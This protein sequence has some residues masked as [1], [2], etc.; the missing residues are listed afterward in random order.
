[1]ELP[2]YQVDA[3]TSRVFGGNPAAVCPLRDWLPAETM[4]AI[5]AENNLA[6]TAFF[7]KQEDGYGLRWF[8]PVVEMPLCGH[9]TLA[10]A[11][12]IFRHLEPEAAV[13][14]F[15]TK[16]G[17]LA[18]E[19]EGERLVLDFPA[20]PAARTQPPP[21]LA[22]GLGAHALEVWKASYY[23]AVFA[24]EDEVRGLQPDMRV[25]CGLDPVI[26]TAPGSEGIDFVSRFFAPSYGIDEDPVTGSAHCTLTPYWA[27]RLKKTALR[28]RQ[29]SRRGGDLWVET[30]GERVRMAGTGVEYLRGTITIPD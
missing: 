22:E 17:V 10:S 12:V 15:H 11:H 9:A 5:A 27:A 4:Q 24:S 7:V 20:L 30:R 28:A 29:V 19:R 2:L 16:S 23:M 13:L 26:C 8:T 25:L 6:E 1:M 14:L 21:M 18:V 3:F